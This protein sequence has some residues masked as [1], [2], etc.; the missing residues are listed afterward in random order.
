MARTSAKNKEVDSKGLYISPLEKE[1]GKIYFRYNSENDN[2]D[3]IRIIQICQNN[4]VRIATPGGVTSRVVE[5]SWLKENGY[6]PLLE[7]A[8]VQLSTVQVG[9]KDTDWFDDVMVTAYQYNSKR[10]YTLPDVICRQ[11]MTDVFYAPYCTDGQNRMVGLSITPDT[12]PAG[13]DMKIFLTANKVYRS[14]MINTYKTDSLKDIYKLFGKD[15]TS[16]ANQILKKNQEAYFKNIQRKTGRR[17]KAAISY[18]GY[19][20]NLF[21][22]LKENNFMYDFYKMYGLTEM[23]YAI[24]TDQ[25]SLTDEQ[26]NEAEKL[27]GITITKNTIIPYNYT[28]NLDQI[29]MKYFLIRDANGITYIIAY[30]SSP[31]EVALGNINPVINNNNQSSNADKLDEMLRDSV[32]FYD[33]LNHRD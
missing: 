4:K 29:N 24:G 9:S 11:G 16:D 5:F 18:D 32:V 23:K 12:C 26:K 28:I 19:C 20:N 30:T 15:M 33:K 13:Y 8:I 25:V 22:L 14:R 27:F 3:Q 10:D 6:D 2:F 7:D 17:P 31:E 1:L 21:Q